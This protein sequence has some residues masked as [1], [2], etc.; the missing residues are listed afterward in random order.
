MIGHSL[1][2]LEE[3]PY[4]PTMRI[5][6]PDST[7]AFAR[8]LLGVT[9]A[10]LTTAVC[11]VGAWAQVPPGSA[12]G[13]PGAGGP[14][15]APA[16][17]AEEPPTEAERYVDLAIK[18]ISEI[19][20]I[21]A[22]VV[23]EVKML[24]Q[25]FTIRGRYLRAPGTR[26]RMD[27]TVSN[28]PDTSGKMIQVSDGETLWDYQQFFET[29][30][31]RKQNI[32]LILEKLNSPDL[33]AETRERATTQLGL[34]GPES[35]LMGLRRTIKFTHMEEATLDG[36]PVMIIEGS[37]RDRTGLVGPDQ[38]NVPAIG[39]LPPYIPSVARLYLG[40]EDSWPYQVS[41]KGKPVPILKA[42]LEKGPDGKPRPRP[43]VND[44]V[45]PTS[46]V[47]TYSNV[48]FDSP[49]TDAEFKFTPPSEVPTEDITETIVGTLDQAIKVRA[50]MS[51]NANPSKPDVPTIDQSIDV[52]K[53]PGDAAPPQ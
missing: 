47:M 36:K 7:S 5:N 46:I 1:P 23:Q 18:K 2:S 30:L 3:L 41:L 24:N 43:V 27:L 45:A 35:L 16:K 39:Q 38:Q 21:S 31:C 22:E 28:L 25:D 20:T 8:T 11:G 19:K 26:F 9:V 34:A 13:A 29:K 40:K 51:K 14:P 52:P 6:R 17:K 49:A 44:N 15:G 10:L 48:K 33:D 42:P 12:P 32:K 50:A 4:I 37:W 53:L